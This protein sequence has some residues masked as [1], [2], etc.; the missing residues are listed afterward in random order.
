MKPADLLLTH[1]TRLD[2]M[3][4][5]HPHQTIAVREGRIAWVGHD[6]ELPA[7]LRGNGTRVESCH[8]ELVTPGLIDCHTHLVYA[9]N[10][11]DDFRQ[12]LLGVSYAEIA[13]AGG[14]ILSTVQKTRAASEEVLFEESLPRLLALQADGVMT[15]EIKSGYGL[16]LESELKMLRVARRLGEHTGMRVRTTFL[17]AHALPPEFAGR[18]AA[19][20]SHL[21]DTM[22]PEVSE[23]GLA[24][25]VDVFCE[26]IAF[27]TDETARIFEKATALGLRVKCHAEQLATTGGAEVA[28]RFNALSCDHLE[29]LD[30]AGIEAMARHG[31]TAVL[32]PGAWYYLGE[33]HRP[34]VERLRARGVGMAISTDSNPGSS[35]TTSLRLMMNMGCR[36]FGLTVAEAW[37]GVTSVAARALGLAGEAGEIAVGQMA[38]L[39]HWRTPESALPCCLFATPIEHRMLRHGQWCMD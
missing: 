13:R 6:N 36:F 34:P 21:C 26:S 29:H 1:T 24:D 10:R 33:T 35:P 17:G 20:V 9:G 25:A 11:A 39:I 5:T 32:L 31:V 12:R 7:E 37:A 4:E 22:L 15:V 2:A 14:G 27:D 28:A 3:G 8:G 23:S 30:E 16:S 19:Y 18:K 38:D